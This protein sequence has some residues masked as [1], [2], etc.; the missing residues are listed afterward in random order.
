[1]PYRRRFARRQFR[2]PRRRFRRRNLLATRQPKSRGMRVIQFKRTEMKNMVLNWSSPPT[3]WT[4]V[5]SGTTPGGE[6]ST[7]NAIVAN[8]EF[9]LNMLASKSDFTNLFSS[10]RIKAVRMTAYY[11]N[12]QS[13]N[14]NT[15]YLLYQHQS[16]FGQNSTSQLTEDFFLQRPS[17]KKRVL[18]NKGSTGKCFDI[19][20]RVNQLKNTYAGTVNTDYGLQPPAW[21]HTNEDSTPHYGVSLRL[22]RVDGKMPTHDTEN[23]YP[24]L[25]V[26][27]TLYIQCRGIS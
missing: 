15:N 23:H 7:D 5:G 9:S 24:T 8:L 14:E 13:V 27:Y 21:I 2:R 1:M 16:N 4:H 22:Q 10:Y 6:D 3:N 18:L 17:S 20:F 25:K 26:F 19:Y 11:S 12:T